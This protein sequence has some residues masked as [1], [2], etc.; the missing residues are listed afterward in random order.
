[1]NWS[2]VFRFGLPA[3]VLLALA[4]SKEKQALV[5]QAIPVVRRDIVVSA[6]AA[7]AIEP[8]RTVD[9]KS[10]ASGEIIAVYVDTG[11]SVKAGQ[12]LVR[13]D[14][15][16]PFNALHQAEANLEVAKAQVEN[17]DAQL[18]RAE[19]LHKSAAI[20]DQEYEQAKLTA[21]TA[22]AQLVSAQRT[23]E[24]SR[25]SYQD[26]D[27]RA[28]SAGTIIARTIQPGMVIQSATSNVGG[29]TTLLQMAN[30]DTVQV[31]SLV[32]ETDIGKIQPGMS[33][34]ITVDAYPNRPFEGS[35]LKIEPQATVQQNVTMFPV[36]V[37]IPNPNHLLK[38]G[39]NTEVEVHV[40]ARSNV[41]AIPNAALRTQRDVSS[42]AT[43]LGLNPDEV[44]KQVAEARQRPAGDSGRATL[45]ATTADPS[46]PDSARKGGET[47]TTPDGRQITL[48]PGLTAARVRQVFEKISSGGFQ[49]LTPEDRQV[50]QQLRQAGGGAGRQGG[51]GFRM[52]MG[53]SGGAGGNG[54]RNGND[55]LFGGSYI[56]FVLRKGKPSP[57][58]VRTGLTDLDY[59]EVMSG[60]TEAD[61]VLILPSAS[62]VAQQQESQEMQNRMRSNAIPGMGAGPVGGGP[63]R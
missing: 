19:D 33:V 30:L 43:V 57:V 49:T 27:V 50:M 15:R 46:K 4:C 32:D 40:G 7:G 55:Y 38:P 14:Q 25:I 11:D 2:R 60:L 59:S 42:A 10:K 5:Y 37:R 62:L 1:M 58:P 12:Q 44:L 61:T 41:L 35:V 29:G 34:T 8:V 23:L 28:P 39:M 21:A 52:M 3:G 6:S 16:I 24:D 13:V 17:A 53:G 31:R 45:A 20:T 26:T 51:G 9:V 22:K 36:L 56:V 48:P 47:F 63:R 18:K 54:A